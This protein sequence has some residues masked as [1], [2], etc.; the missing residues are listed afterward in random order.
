MLNRVKKIA[1]I[2]PESTGKSTLCE[3]LALH[4]KTVHV[5]EV[6]RAYLNNL[7]TAYSIN[8]LDVITTKQLEAE[9]NLMAKADRILFCDTDAYV[10]KIWSEVKY[11]SCSLHILNSI[12]A[13]NYDYYL[14]TNIDM[15]WQEDALREHPEP[16]MRETLMRMYLDTMQNC[17]VPFSLVSGI[18]EERL[19]NAIR[20][21]DTLFS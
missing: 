2:G 4:F 14:L 15:P 3:A 20:A 11:N 16:H 10:I 6:A 21:V 7:G 5:Q 8:D 17:G 13:S 18:G 12:V 9:E 19:Q 1:V